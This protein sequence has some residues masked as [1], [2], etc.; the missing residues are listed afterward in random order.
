MMGWLLRWQFG[1]GAVR[2][3][4]VMASEGYALASVLARAELNELPLSDATWFAG[5]E[6]TIC[7]ATTV[8]ARHHTTAT[9]SQ[10]STMSV[11]RPH[12]HRARL[13]SPRSASLQTQ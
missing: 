7:R 6:R 12:A 2:A 1:L 3:D 9:S 11:A 10:T 5:A 13:Q 4:C 8:V